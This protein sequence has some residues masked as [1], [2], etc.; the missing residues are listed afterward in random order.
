MLNRSGK[1]RSFPVV[2]E[3]KV[4]H[5]KILSFKVDYF[6]F[7][8]EIFEIQGKLDVRVVAATFRFL[9]F[10]RFFP[11]FSAQTRLFL[12]QKKKKYIWV[13]FPLNFSHFF[14]LWHQK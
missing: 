6:D 3:L 7:S 2:L 5:S 1:I 4:E 9:E 8:C 12:N 13:F 14:Q 11:I 10:F